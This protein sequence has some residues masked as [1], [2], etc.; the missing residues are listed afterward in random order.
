M[1]LC[2]EGPNHGL[3]LRLVGCRGAWGKIT[4]QVRV[5]PPEAVFTL[6]QDFTAQA[7]DLLGHRLLVI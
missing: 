5:S 4:A 6:L 2:G 7:G 1:V 3:R